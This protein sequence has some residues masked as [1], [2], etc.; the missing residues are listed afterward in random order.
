MERTEMLCQ[1]LKLAVEVGDRHP[2]RVEF[3]RGNGYTVLRLIRKAP[4]G[5]LTD[6]WWLSIED[7]EL[8]E[9]FER[10]CRLIAQELTD[11]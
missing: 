4:D 10:L 6:D 8:P 9:L 1:L 2:E 3:F 5:H 7:G 11:P